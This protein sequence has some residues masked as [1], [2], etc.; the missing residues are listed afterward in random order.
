M[1]KAMLSL[2]RPVNL[3][4]LRI[5]LLS[6]LNGWRITLVLSAKG[7]REDSVKVVKGVCNRITLHWSGS[8]IPTG[9]PLHE[10]QVVELLCPP[11]GFRGR[12]TRKLLSGL[13]RIA[14]K[15]GWS[16]TDIARVAG[17]S[18]D[19]GCILQPLV[20]PIH[21]H[22]FTTSYLSSEWRIT[23]SV[24][25]QCWKTWLQKDIDCYV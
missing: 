7:K 12:V 24:F 1:K 4:F 6:S 8:S 9:N 13:Q 3:A 21:L 16:K 5:S 22:P 25:I 10:E 15:A 20:Y 2:K 17:K 14:S 11:W 19:K 18:E 23:I